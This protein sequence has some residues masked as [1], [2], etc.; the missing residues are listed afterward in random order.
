[1]TAQ[2]FAAKKKVATTSNK[3]V[4]CKEICP[5]RDVLDYVGDKWSMLIIL[6]LGSQSPLRFGE[7]KTIIGGISQKMLTI[8]LRQLEH[9]GFV[10]RVYFP[11]VPPRVEYSITPLGESLMEALSHLVKWANDNTVAILQARQKSTKNSVSS[12][13]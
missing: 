12:K 8:T 13:E 6:Q 9:D 1:M 4:A 7:L 3:K 10:Q 11:E 5:V 2:A